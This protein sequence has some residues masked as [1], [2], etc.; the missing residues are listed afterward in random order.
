M[1]KE[2]IKRAKK[3]KLILLDCDGV[4]TDGKL[5]FGESGEMIKAFHVRDGQGIVSWHKLG[6]LSGIISGRNSKIVEKRGNEL[7]IRF[8]RQS[9]SDKLEDFNEILTECG[10]SAEETAYIGDDIPDIDLLKIVG[11]SF[12]VADA[13]NEVFPIVDIILKNNG[14]NGA[15]REM[16]DLLITAKSS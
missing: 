9:S 13:S 7:G 3:I 4:L 15:V 16:I 2:L 11:L 12:T 6:F 1:N 8:I 14:G 5:Y 10:L